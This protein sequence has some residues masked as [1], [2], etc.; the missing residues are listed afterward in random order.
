VLRNSALIRVLNDWAMTISLED[1][2]VMYAM[3]VVTLISR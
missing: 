2:G 1:P 3:L